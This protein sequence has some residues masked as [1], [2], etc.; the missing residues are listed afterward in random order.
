M[1]AAARQPA[2][3]PWAPGIPRGTKVLF[4]LSAL[5]A[6]GAE[7]V[8]TA[9]GN[10]WR[11][12]GLDVAIATFERHDARSFY[13]IDPGVAVHRLNVAADPSSLIPALRQVSRRVAALSRLIHR[14]RPGVV[15]SFLTKIN[16]V[17]LLAAP[18]GTPVIV[19]ERNNPNLQRFN[20]FWR[21][22][23]AFT[24][25]KAFAFVGITAGAVGAYP[26][27]QR[28]NAAIIENPVILPVGLQRR[29][30]GRTLTAVG[31]LTRQKRFD[32]LLDAFAQVAGAFPDWRLIIWGEGPLRPALE[33]QRE[34]LGLGGRVQM[35]GLSDR[36]GS[37]LETA[38]LLVSSSDYEGWGN[39]IAEAMAM[40]VPV[41]A[42][43][44]DF[45]PRD[46]I[47]Q[48]VSGLLVEP[49]RADTLALGLHR[50]LGDETLRARLAA[51]GV[52]RA[53]AFALPAI[54]QRWETLI[55]AALAKNARGRSIRQTEAPANHAA[56][57]P[58]SK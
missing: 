28:P 1:T 7:R 39:V 16:V 20:A 46:I 22:A 9:L 36:P 18:A 11:R 32:L 57:V 6:G 12:N 3:G 10:H 13:P 17:A 42:T 21:V 23:K 27:R 5:G 43:D 33:A 47:D 25:P 31:R 34:R 48:E 51:A 26:A 24:F 52:A 35:P 50:L 56:A 38:D 14:E 40:G 4:V 15:I 55:A 2:D 45:G 54:A 58:G 44:C 29:S 8:A 49:G 19:S 53:K 30:D 37:W 41:I